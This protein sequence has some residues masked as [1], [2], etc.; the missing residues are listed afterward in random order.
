MRSGLVAVL[1]APLIGVHILK[2]SAPHA[3]PG[4]WMRG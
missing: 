3:A 4:R 2:A 1:F